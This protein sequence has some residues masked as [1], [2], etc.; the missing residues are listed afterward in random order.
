MQE[1]LKA[2]IKATIKSLE[3]EYG[4]NLELE[5]PIDS[6]K[7]VFAIAGNKKEMEKL[8]NK[9]LFLFKGFE[10]KH[11]CEFWLSFDESN[12]ILMHIYEYK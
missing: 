10:I 6:T 5:F 3:T 8:S 7:K 4:I 9:F 12:A 1:E 11:N 2:K